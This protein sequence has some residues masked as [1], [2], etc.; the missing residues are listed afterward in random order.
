MKN[1][2]IG[3]QLY[4]V[5]NLAQNAEDLKNTL[6]SLKEM[7]YN[8]CQLS[9]QSREIPDEVVRDLLLET[10]MTPV[11]TH[12]SMDDFDKH[13]D[14]LIRRHK[15]WGVKY[16]GLG[17]MSGE[18]NKSAEGFKAFAAHVNGIAKTL[19]SEGLTFVYHNHA[20]EFER[21][22]GV[23]GMDILFDNFCPEAQFELDTY[24]VQAGGCDPVEWIRKVDGRMDV[25]HFKDMSGANENG[26]HHKMVPIG[27]GNLN[28]KEIIRACEETGVKYIEIEQD[29]AADK[30]CPLGEMK[31]SIEYL[32][33]MG[34]RF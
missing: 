32:K 31:A 4:S 2:I 7:G 11:V 19:A 21:F 14:A 6:K 30:A 26:Q 20:F 22:D 12:N 9:G 1:F 13:L 23:L 29:N 27:S 10:G 33:T 17:A 28:W 15:L 3:A 34:V 25:G 18:Y 5:R 16:A 8:T 24:W